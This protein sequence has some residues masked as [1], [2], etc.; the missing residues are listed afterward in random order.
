VRS[1]S[2]AEVTV[3]LR[4]FGESFLKLESVTR[5]EPWRVPLPADGVAE[6]WWFSLESTGASRVCRLR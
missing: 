3:G 5:L 1:P 6:P 4:R 2:A